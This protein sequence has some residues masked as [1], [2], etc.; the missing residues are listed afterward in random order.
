[1]SAV[2][3]ATTLTM[4]THPL[5]QPRGVHPL[6]HSVSHLSETIG[7][8]VLSEGAIGDVLSPSSRFASIRESMSLWSP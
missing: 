8:L 2:A 4:A 6:G 5:S 1:M 3:V 7:R